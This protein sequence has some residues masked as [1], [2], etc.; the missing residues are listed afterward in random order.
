MRACVRDD[1]FHRERIPFPRFH[2]DSSKGSRSGPH[3]SKLISLIL[4]SAGTAESVMNRKLEDSGQ[5]RNTESLERNILVLQHPLSNPHLSPSTGPQAAGRNDRAL[6]GIE[7][8]LHAT[9]TV[10]N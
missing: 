6:A 9:A 4:Q 8:S 5:K 2:G 3:R 7:E 10:M 1:T